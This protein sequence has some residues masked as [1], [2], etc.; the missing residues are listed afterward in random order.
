[1]RIVKKMDEMGRLVILHPGNIGAAAQRGCDPG[2]GGKPGG[3]GKR[4][5][6]M[7]HL[8]ERQGADEL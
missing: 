7:P 1:M 2:T 8:R 3:A 5:Q 4:R 6:A